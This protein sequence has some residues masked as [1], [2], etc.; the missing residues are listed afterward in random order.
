MA[1]ARDGSIQVAFGLGKYTNRNVMD[2]YAGTSRGVEQTT[3]RVSR[4]LSPDPEVTTLGPIRYEVVE[5]LQRIRFVLEPN[6]VQPIAFDWRFEG[7]LPPQFEDRTHLRA[8]YRVSAELVRYHQIGRCSGWLEIDGEHINISPEQWVS[9]RDHSWGVRY[10]VG[11]EP[12]DLEPPG[13]DPH[14]AFHFFWTPSLLERPDGS[15]Y[16]VFMAMCF[17]G[18]TD[19]QRSYRRQVATTEVAA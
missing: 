13:D 17:V 7:V 5:P 12:T 18:L 9:T 4:R 3:V 15:V 1:A 10:G 11:T 14:S 8:G 16:G 2:A 6:D 19:W